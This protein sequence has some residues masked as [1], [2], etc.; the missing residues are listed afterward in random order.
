M[1]SLER[2]VSDGHRVIPCCVVDNHCDVVPFLQAAW[3]AKC[4]PF[5]GLEIVHFDVCCIDCLLPPVY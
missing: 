3:K 5:T 2:A 4:L 1:E